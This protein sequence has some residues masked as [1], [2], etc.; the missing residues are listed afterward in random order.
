[1]A[2]D[3][4]QGA[5]P[6]G[7][8]ADALAMMSAS[9]NQADAYLHEQIAVARAQ[10]EVLRLQAEDLRREDKLRHWS[11]RVHHISDVMKLTFELSLAAIVLAFATLIGT[12][13]W[14]ASH[15][16]SLVVESFSV[17]ADLAA[18]GVT[19]EAVAAQLQDK[20]TAMQAA[21]NS[22]RPPDSYANN[23]GADI[24]VQIPDTGVSVGEFYRLLVSWF[25]SQTHISGE[26][27]RTAD[28]L[29]VTTRATGE[30]G[31]VVRGSEKDLDALMQK[32]AETVYART[33]PFRYAVYLVSGPNPDGVTS[34]VLL[35]N[36]ARTGSAQDR[37]WAYMG[38]GTREEYS[39][40][41]HAPKTHALAIPLTPRF[42]LPY[43]NIASEEFWA[44]HDETALAADRNAVALL[45]QGDGE[46]SARASAISLPAGRARAE[47]MIGDFPEA[48]RQDAQ[49]V[50]EP[51]YAFIAEYCR[52]DM[53]YDEAMQHDRAAAR[54]DWSGVPV[55]SNPHG[56]VQY[57]PFEVSV[58]Y[59]LGDWNG[60]IRKTGEFES[61]LKTI[62][63]VQ[64]FTKSFAPVTLSR[65]V[66]PY[67]AGALART[68]HMNDALALIGRT[69][70]DCDLCVRMCGNIATLN[71]DWTGAAH[72]FAMVSARAPSIPFADADWGA[73]LMA[74]GDFDGAIAKFT[75]ANQKGPHFA[76]PLEM[77]GEALIARNRSDL[78]L[79]KF[80]EANKY[81]PN[82]GRLH[83]KWGEALWWSGDKDGAKKQFDAAQILD[84]T[85]A[86]KSELAREGA[87]HVRGS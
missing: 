59:G 49:C 1:M 75:L 84:L 6:P 43:Q 32:A 31:D 56:A 71:H 87:S 22:A 36:L 81:A 78:A 54:G 62:E 14:K 82:W 63:R 16:H 57:R 58:L 83:L 15:D 85:L 40:P 13:I 46:M 44:G 19:G 50:M 30:A 47:E 26:M 7:S 11:L 21:T 42:A 17:P 33:Q 77:W 61:Y 39:D 70:L 38:L 45:A 80:E 68:G 69:P 2:E 73:M 41:L 60:V 76:D 74:K 9:R 64:P 86:E 28:G 10:A 4:N 8:A 67:T 29:A 23:W 34:L 51:D 79:A 18:R 25:G 35:Q 72:W 66:W 53:A 55:P 20:L 65:E 48:L 37:S 3:A 52:S 27:Y 24:K 5:V 12:A